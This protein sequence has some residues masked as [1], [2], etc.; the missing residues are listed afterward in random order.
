M[1]IS[2]SETKI[3]IIPSITDTIEALKDLWLIGDG[4]LRE[5]VASLQ[6]LKN[7]AALRDHRLPYIYQYY[8]VKGYFHE[9]NSHIDTAI[10]RIYNSM[11]FGLNENTFLPKYVIF[12]IDQDIITCGNI[13]N[14]GSGTAIEMQLKHLVKEIKR[15]LMARREDLKFRRPGAL[16]PS[17]EPRLIWV[18]MIRRPYTEE[19]RQANILKQRK[20]FNEILS[21]ILMYEKYMYLMQIPVELSSRN[22]LPNGNLTQEGKD[23]YWLK[24][25]E[26]MK[27]FDRGDVTLK[28]WEDYKS[29]GNKQHNGKQ[30][31]HK[32]KY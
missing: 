3:C 11:V 28:P 24:L 31:H 5:S 4:F 30:Q 20:K 9:Y 18:E 19:P 21:S 7:G 26:I 12:I 16:A 1:F 29:G 13:Y 15:W 23:G 6:Q 17:M 25:D 22:F 2:T 10:G 8:N 14:F 32:G 27:K